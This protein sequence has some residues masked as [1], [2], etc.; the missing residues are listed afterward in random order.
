MTGPPPWTPSAER[1]AQSNL[2]RFIDRI[3][4]RFG[5]NLAS[6]DGIHGFSIAQPEDFWSEVWDFCGVTAETR[7]TRILIDGARMRDARFFPDARLNYAENL[8]RKS[9]DTPAL[10]FRGEDKVRSSMTWRELNA[11]V[12]RLHRAL[13]ASGIKAGDRVCAVVPNM[14]ETIVC[15]LAVASLGAIWSS[16][17]PDFGAS[18]ILDRF[19]QIGPRVLI[20][21]D[22]Y[23]Y[24]GKTIPMAGKIGE[25]LQ[26]L[27]TVERAVIIDYIGEAES[28]AKDLRNGVGYAGFVAGHDNGPISFPRMPFD[29]PLYILYSSG[30]TGVPK[31]IVHRAGGI[32]L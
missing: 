5:L 13:A 10:I 9:D 3:N 22:G 30:T 8:L 28:V 11:S 21:C 6:Y 1:K 2:Q 24:A 23:Y 19:G 15:F 16:C 27:P 25:V 20:A 32:L 31:C 7:G 29:H 12:A 26:S 4:G 17:S 14:P 18:G